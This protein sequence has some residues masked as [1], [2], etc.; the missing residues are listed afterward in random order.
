[1]RRE[2]EPRLADCRDH[3]DAAGSHRLLQN[4]VAAPAQ[5][6]REHRGDL[7]LMTGGRIDVD[8]LSC[9]RERVYRIHASSSVRA[10]V[11]S[12]RYLTMTGV[13]SASPHS[14]PAPTVTLRAP[15]T[16]TAP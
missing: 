4:R 12:S 6:R 13:T 11:L 9:E 16:T 10:S 2:H 7:G 5:I 14:R 8:Q 1:M 3:I 15:G